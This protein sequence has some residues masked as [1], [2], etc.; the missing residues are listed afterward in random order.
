MRNQLDTYT[1][2]D[3]GAVYTPEKTTFRLWAPT[4]E[5]VS[6]CFYREGNGDCL[7]GRKVMT[8]DK[9][10]TWIYPKRGDLDGVYYTFLVKVDGIERETVDPYA[11][12]VG[13]NGERA[14]V[15]DLLSTN[16]DG[17][18]DD[19]GPEVL[20]ATDVIVSEISV[21]D[22]TRDRSSGVKHP[23]KYLGLTE[24]GTKSPDGVPTG[25]DYL[26]SLG[27]T[28]VQLMPAFDFASVDEA[29][30]ELEQYNWGYDPLNYNVP[31]GSFST[32]PFHGEVRIR[33]FKQMVQ[34]F[35]KENI[36]VIMDVV[37]NHTFD[38]ENSC[39]QK[40]VPDYFYRKAG[41]EYSGASGC[42]NEIASERPMVRKYIID[43]VT[44]WA[45]EYHIDGFRFD[46]MGVLDLQ[47]MQELRDALVE[48]NPSILVYGEGWTGGDS[49]LPEE[50]RALKHNISK[51]NYVGAFSD[52]IRDT[53]RGHVFYNEERGF[54]SGKEHLENDIRYSVA[55]AAAHPQVDYK[56]YT[57]TPSGPWAKNPADTINYVSCHDNLTLWDK[58]HVSCPEASEE[59]LLA[60]NRLA[61]AV[62]FTSQGVPFFLLGE[63]F[64]R[65]KPVEGS[66]MPSENSYNL[67]F[68]TNSIKYGRVKGYEQLYHYYRGLIAFRKAHAGL[69]M[70]TAKEVNAN[71]RF[72]D[73]GI[74]N[75]VAFTIRTPEE[76]IFVVYNANK[77]DVVI[78]LPEQGAFSVCIENGN[79]GT[80]C[81]RS[82]ADQ[83]TVKAVSCLA[84]VMIG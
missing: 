58:L 25:L 69:R 27:I 68:Y 80:E 12:A 14:M 30:P 19:K 84:A 6:V 55:G 49:V 66:D 8:K 24:K 77:E 37:F 29:H 81:L 20:N 11:K 56:K 59:E 42:G 57:Y 21:S 53:L 52:D 74:A 73:T 63:E 61:A 64:A 2:D 39:F 48:I 50:E 44:Y 26:K 71:L 31:E 10:G 79:A 75:V 23:G 82:I 54:V 70:P 5:A 51:M 1:K 62:V 65:T 16:P 17:F 40:T 45:K 3:L 43:S 78:N 41:S 35:H 32:D 33:E 46:L 72:E 36:G 67:P 7:L 34:A 60:M 76:T 28:H 4:A 83:T 13:V 18:L 22:M 38:V 47:T 9:N 15:V